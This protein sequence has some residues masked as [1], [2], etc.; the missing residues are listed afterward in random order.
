MIKRIILEKWYKTVQSTSFFGSAGTFDIFMNPSRYEVMKE[1]PKWGD[2]LNIRGLLSLDSKE[3]YVWE[4]FKETHLN[5]IN[6]VFS[7]KNFICLEFAL[8]NNAVYLTTSNFMYSSELLQYV[9]TIKNSQVIKDIMRLG[10]ENPSL[11]FLCEL[12]G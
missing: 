5:L 8:L 3:L 9:K 6:H 1:I 2:F 4:A 12:P 10:Y 11:I 7:K